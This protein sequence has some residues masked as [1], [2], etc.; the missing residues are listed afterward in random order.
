MASFT[1]L[2]AIGMAGVVLMLIAYALT[3]SGR[4]D[5][6][7]PAALVCNLIGA[8]AVLVSLTRAF[9]WSSAVIESAWAVI[10]AAGLVR[11]WLRSR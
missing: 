8:V 2:D 11:W 9:N 4:I 7:R 6:L 3:V 10:A 1:P 5:P